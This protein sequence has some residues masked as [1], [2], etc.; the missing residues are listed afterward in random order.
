MRIMCSLACKEINIGGWRGWRLRVLEGFVIVLAFTQLLYVLLLHAGFFS[1]S[2][3][4]GYRDR[5]YGPGAEPV[6]PKSTGA[7]I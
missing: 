5:D 1:S 3:G 2:Y 4:P 7:G 6:P